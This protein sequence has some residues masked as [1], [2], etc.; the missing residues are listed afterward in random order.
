M[1]TTENNESSYRKNRHIEKEELIGERLED[2]EMLVNDFSDKIKRLACY[3]AFQ[4]AIE[5]LF[6]IIAMLVKDKGKLV[7]DDYTNVDKLEEAGVL[8]EQNAKVLREAN[9]LRN[10]I[11]HRYNKTDDNIARESILAI[12][13]HLKDIISKI[14]QR[15]N[16]K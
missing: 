9:G 3:K 2:V 8:S 4:E 7:E 16:E 15:K 10:R 13:P 6:D 12:M 1:V 11:V 5:A 14:M